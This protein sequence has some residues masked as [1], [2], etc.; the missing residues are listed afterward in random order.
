[1]DSAHYDEG[2]FLYKRRVDPA[3]RR[4]V[5]RIKAEFISIKIGMM[6]EI[7][8]IVD[9]CDGPTLLY[10]RFAWLERST[11]LADRVSHATQASKSYARK[12]GRDRCEARETYYRVFLVSHEAGDVH[13]NV[14]QASKPQCRSSSRG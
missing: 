9:E 6:H 3:A 14:S 11:F 12:Y 2:T 7:T 1:M 13:R 5:S 4:L 8:V 10:A